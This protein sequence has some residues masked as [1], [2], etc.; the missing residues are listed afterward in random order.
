MDVPR[1]YHPDMTEAEQTQAWETSG[2]LRSLSEQSAAFSSA[3]DLF[4]HAAELSLPYEQQ[5]GVAMSH[6]S[7][8]EL[9]ASAKMKRQILAVLD[10]FRGWQLVAVRDGA[11]TIYHFGQAMAAARTSA[12]KCKKLAEIIDR[13]KMK[14]AGKLFAQTFPNDVKVRNALGHFVELTSIPENRA[15]NSFT[16]KFTAPGVVIEGKDNV[17]NVLS[18]AKLSL[19]YG[20]EIVEYELSRANFEALLR[21]QSL[22]FDAFRAVDLNIET[23]WRLEKAQSWIRGYGVIEF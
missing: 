11:M 22:L 13:P 12:F 5:L 20:N 8:E 15:E 23:K 3:L 6:A 17:I 2:I 10:R 16:G 9:R 1:L 7:V 19:T 18:G 21:V 14:E 4:D